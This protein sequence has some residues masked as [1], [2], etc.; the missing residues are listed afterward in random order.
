MLTYMYIKGQ[1]ILI[2]VC[3]FNSSHSLCIRYSKAVANLCIGVGGLEHSFIVRCA[4]SVYI[5][6]VILL[7]SMSFYLQ[8]T[9]NFFF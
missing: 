3:V 7:R 6:V 4:D 2:L 8:N 5:W 1:E 9:I